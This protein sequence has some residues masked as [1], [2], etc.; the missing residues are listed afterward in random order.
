[1]RTRSYSRKAAVA[2]GAQVAAASVAAA[3]NLTARPRGYPRC[4]RHGECQ[5]EDATLTYGLCTVGSISPHTAGLAF[6]CGAAAPRP[7]QLATAVG[8]ALFTLHAHHHNQN[9]SRSASSSW[10]GW[11]A[12]KGR[13]RR[14]GDRRGARLGARCRSCVWGDL[15]THCSL[16]FGCTGRSGGHHLCLSFSAAA[17]RNHQQ[18]P[19]PTNPL[20]HRA[21]GTRRRWRRRAAH[22]GGAA[23]AD[24]GP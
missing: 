22:G 6:L 14:S 17:N 1:V 19:K 3:R 23:T 7:L 8:A 21:Q 11:R 20:S 9:R 10:S 12:S 15:R 13:I 4:S 16:A 2:R 18:P 24:A 5:G